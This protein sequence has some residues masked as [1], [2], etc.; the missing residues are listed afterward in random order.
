MVRRHRH[1]RRHR[2]HHRPVAAVALVALVAVAA[3]RDDGPYVPTLADGT[4]AEAG[5]DSTDEGAADDTRGTADDSPDGE[6]QAASATSTAAPTTTVTAPHATA[7]ATAAPTTT[8]RSVATT[9][10]TSITSTRPS[11]PQFELLEAPGPFG[12]GYT[13]IVAED[14][15]R[16]VERTLDVWYPIPRGTSGAAGRYRFTDTL[17]LDSATAIADARPATGPFPL[18]VYSHGSG[19]LRYIASFFTE[20]LASYGFVVA[21]PDHTGNTT[22]ELL[23]NATADPEQ[24]A[25]DRPLDV[26]F[27][28][29]EMQFRSTTAS[30]LLFGTIDGGP[31]GVTGHSAGGFTAIATATGHENELGSSDPDSR[32]GAVVAMAPATSAL[33]D[34]ELASLTVPTM[35]IGGS[36]DRTTPV[37][38]QM[39]RPWSLMNASPALF[40][41][42]DDV[43]HQ[44]FTDVCS[45]QRVVPSLPDVPDIVLATIDD[46]AADGCGPGFMP[47]GAA[48]DL[49]NT[50][51]ISFLQTYLARR[52]GFDGSLSP[53]AEGIPGSVTV[54][55][56]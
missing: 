32:I 37:D 3:C 54:L 27:V 41:E 33:S 8:T 52:A 12:V 36:A 20:R 29:D 24:I 28:I 48:H 53:D 56:T 35:L 21:A 4:S 6:T 17:Y 31:V 25:L 42:I 13:T 1:Q 46:F 2:R 45:Y 39:T 26:S 5:G 43:G 47:D 30:D 55:A 9:S 15:L 11:R 22:F 18:V 19:G 51:V 10:T 34:D 49:I 7:P 16:A 40:V 44:T 50:Y 14:P 23:A 38:P